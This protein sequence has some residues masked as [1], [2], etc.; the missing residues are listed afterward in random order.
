MRLVFFTIDEHGYSLTDPVYWC[1]ASFPTGL[2]IHPVRNT[3]RLECAIPSTSAVTFD[4]QLPASSSSSSTRS[5]INMYERND[6][7]LIVDFNE[8]NIDHITS[9]ERSLVSSKIYNLIVIDLISVSLVHRLF[10]LWC[11]T[12]RFPCSPGALRGRPCCRSRTERKA[13]ISSRR[14][15]IRSSSSCIISL[16]NAGIFTVFLCCTFVSSVTG[17]SWAIFASE[18]LMACSWSASVQEVWP[19]CRTRLHAFYSEPTRR[20]CIPLPRHR[21]CDDERASIRIS[22]ADRLLPCS[23]G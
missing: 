22:Y 12:F 14:V 23:Y 19:L 21:N 1:S 5:L 10:L 15:A 11:T 2:H 9:L 6:T 20:S 13:C 4:N 17:V 8:S 18:L 7:P 3:S 16:D